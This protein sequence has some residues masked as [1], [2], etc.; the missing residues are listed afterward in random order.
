MKKLKHRG[1]IRV[2]LDTSCYIAA[3]LSKNGAS[4]RLFELVVKGKLLN[5]YTADILT[6]IKYVLNREK[7]HLEKEKQN[8]FLC[9]IQESSFCIKQLAE[10]RIKKCRDPDDD[11]FLSLALQVDADYLITIDN[12]LLVLMTIGRTKVISP[13]EVLQSMD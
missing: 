11:K 7:F 3:L 10:Y 4:A 9:I 12:D 8:R 13:A 1:I 6:E 5:F 2:V